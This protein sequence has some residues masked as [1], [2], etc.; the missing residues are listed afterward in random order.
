[1]ANYPQ[2][3]TT[4]FTGDIVLTN[5]GS[6]GVGTTAPT[7]KFQVSS[8]DM[9]LDSGYRL[10]L[11]GSFGSSPD[12]NWSIGKD[13]NHNVNIRG[14]STGTRAFQ[15][16]DSVSEEAVRLHV[17]FSGAVGIGNT[18]PE[19]GLHIGASA[20]GSNKGYI[21]EENIGQTPTLTID[22]Q[23]AIYSKGN[24]ICIAKRVS[25][26]TRYTS[27]DMSGNGNSWSTSTTTA[28]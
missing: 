20:G 2:T 23:M 25:G 1:M 3:T 6:V 28:P 26:T 7:T 21:I 16:I 17:E 27:I 18:A 11:N 15:V 10:Y 19:S 22:G 13:D 9:Q 5:G 8:G 12:T 4:P 24:K 14:A